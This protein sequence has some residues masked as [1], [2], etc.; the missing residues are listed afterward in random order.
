MNIGTILTIIGVAEEVIEAIGE[1]IDL[2]D[3]VSP[4]K[5]AELAS[6]RDAAKDAWDNL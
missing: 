3:D 6:K 1:L 2:Q 4:E 5:L